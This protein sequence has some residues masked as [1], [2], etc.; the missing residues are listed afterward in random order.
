M[1]RQPVGVA[2]AEEV[3]AYSR[4]PSHENTYPS[5]TCGSARIRVFPRDH[6]LTFGERHQRGAWCLRGRDLE[7]PR[8]SRAIGLHVDH[9]DPKCPL[10]P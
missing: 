9:T 10:H 1:D 2:V 4:A 5:S 3:L 6:V 8:G 7:V